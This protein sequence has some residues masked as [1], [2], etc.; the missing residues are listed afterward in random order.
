LNAVFEEL[1]TVGGAEIY[2]RSS[3]IYGIPDQD[4]SFQKIQERVFSMG[5]IALGIRIKNTP[6]AHK[7]GISLNPPKNSMWKLKQSDEIVALTT[8]HYRP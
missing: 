3:G 8:Y 7:G 2:F 4:M 6:G 1:F 5:D